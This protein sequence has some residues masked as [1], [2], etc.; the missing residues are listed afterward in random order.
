[1]TIKGILFDLYGTLIN[2]ETD[3]NLDEI[4]RGI[5]HYLTYHGVYLSR[6]EV[7]ER[8]WE[9]LKRQKNE[10]AEEYPEINVE[11]IWDS[12]L[13]NEGIVAGVD[14]RKLAIILAQM[15]R[16][17]S[18]KRLVLYPD[19]KKVL[20][21]LKAVYP[22]ALVSDAQPCFALPEIRAVGLE[23]YFDPIV[24]SAYHEYRKPDPR[25]YLQALK[26]ME[27]DADEAIYIGN[28][29]FRD[30]FGAQRVGLKTIF[31]DTN[32]GEKSHE[33]VTPDCMTS[34]F[35]EIPELITRINS[36]TMSSAPNLIKSTL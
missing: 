16:G 18:R 11:A 10:S 4:F 7:R 27:L 12:F 21:E 15:F 13:D 35:S 14:R 9:I 20:D 19:V 3:E 25:L 30:I 28:D 34:S 5:G 6:T 8:Y 36:R 32:Q 24:I 23:G 29:M 33:S 2:I 31:L 17:I 22:L 1:M 26:A